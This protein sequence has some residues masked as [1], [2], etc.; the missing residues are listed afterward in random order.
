MHV[1]QIK[2]AGKSGIFAIIEY[3]PV[4]NNI[5]DTKAN[6]LPL[7]CSWKHRHSKNIGI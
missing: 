7:H 3:E 4:R 2:N 6:V 5:C 1:I